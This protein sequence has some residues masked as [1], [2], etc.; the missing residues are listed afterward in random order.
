MLTFVGRYCIDFSVTYPNHF[1]AV[2]FLGFHI[3]GVP[4]SVLVPILAPV[5]DSSNSK[6]IFN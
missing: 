1:H 4:I 3:D 2:L 5:S 6:L